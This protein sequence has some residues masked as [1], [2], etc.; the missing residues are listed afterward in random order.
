METETTPKLGQSVVARD[1]SDLEKKRQLSD[2]DCELDQNKQRKLENKQTDDEINMPTPLF[3]VLSHKE[4]GKTLTKVSPFLIHKSLVACGGQPKSIRKLRNGTILVEAANCIQSKK[5]LKMT[6]F[7]DQVPI[8]VQPHASLNS[9]KGIVFC[10]DLMDCSEEEI[11]DELQCEM[12]TDVVRIVRTENGVKVPTP[13]LIITFAKPHPPETIKAGYLSLSV[14]PYFKNP[15]RCFRCQRFGHSSKVCSNPETCSRCGD[16]GHQEEGCKNETRCINCKGKHPA[17][18]RDCNIFKE[19]REILKIM[20]IE[21]LSF[22]EARKEYRRRVAPTPK[23]GVSYSE[24]V[25]VPV[26]TAQCSS[27]TVLEGMVRALTE[28]VAAL[29][30]HLAAGAG[31]QS[32]VLPSKSPRDFQTSSKPNITS[33]K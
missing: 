18:S 16:E 25:S 23:K 2:S 9:S 13:G 20:T 22:N 24:A 6:S 7:F 12:V 14:R 19:E 10:R 33:K 15:Q 17:Y 3:L 30:Q 31:E 28:Q 27:C 1:Q 8:T 4:D 29:V 5:F 26:Q 32:V 11:K 21:K